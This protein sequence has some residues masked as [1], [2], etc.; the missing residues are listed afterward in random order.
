MEETIVEEVASFHQKVTR[1]RDALSARRAFEQSMNVLCQR[2]ARKIVLFLDEF[3]APFRSLDPSF[4]R[5]LRAVRDAYKDRVSYIVV[6]DNPTRLRDDLTQAEHFYRLTSRNVCGV[7]PYNEVDA[8][9][10]IH[11]LASRRSIEVDP[12]DVAYLIELS[13]GHAGLLKAT[14]G[15][16][17]EAH[18][19]S[20]LSELAPALMG[21]PTIQ[22]ECEKMWYGLSENERDAL[23]A[24]AS[25]T[26]V[27]PDVLRYLELKGLVRENEP[28]TSFF[29]PLFA[30]FVQ[31][32]IPPA[33]KNTIVSRSPQVVRIDGRD[34]KTLTDLEFEALY[35]LYEHWGRVCTK[36]DLIANVYRQQYDRTRGGVTD[37][38][39]QT[40]ISRLRSKI[41]PDR[42]RPR[43]V[44]T[45]RGEGY[46][47][48]VPGEQ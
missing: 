17:W 6:T 34:I 46:K 15:L 36:D 20:D 37:E 14:L 24:L 32:Q 22:A 8:R 48:V 21:E 33:M 39:L 41:E 29:S 38:M 30:D 18:R 19:E 11:Y 10:M 1:S 43:Y 40:L 23:Y 2:P 5:C 42:G 35:C 28:G 3:D 4:F 7:G 27:I 31:Q 26:Q 45:V 16:L 47:F 44:V 12:K 25:G 13:G 9:Q